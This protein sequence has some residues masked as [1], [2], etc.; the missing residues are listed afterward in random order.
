M[1]APARDQNRDNTKDGAV[2]V[3]F[4][5]AVL[6]VSDDAPA[7]AGWYRD[8]LGIPLQD[9]QHAGG[10]EGLHFG[11]SLRDLHFAIHPTENYSFAPETGRG[12]VRIAF[13]VEDIA[14]VAD[15]LERPDVDWVFRPVDLGWSTMLAVRDPDGNMIELLQMTPRITT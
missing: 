13:Q 6:I 5:N 11:C 4:L 14:A 7:L 10:G 9:E 3:D 2:N 1:L 15:Q 12:G 8:V